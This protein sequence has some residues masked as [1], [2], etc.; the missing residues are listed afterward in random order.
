[1]NSPHR[2]PGTAVLAVAAG[3]LLASCSSAGAS[4]SATPGTTGPTAPGH[5][6][7][8]QV[9]VPL[10]GALQHL[11]L[12]DSTGR[13]RSLGDFR[14]KVLVLAPGMTLC[15]DS[16]PID[17]AGLVATARQV[18]R[19][20][21]RDKVEFVTVTVDPRRD[22]P[23][24]LAAYRKLFKPAPANW[25][26]LTGSQH[27]VMALWHTL[28]VYVKKVKGD[29]QPPPKNWRTGQP[30]RYDVDHSDEVFF[31]D[32][33]QHDRF[34]LEGM[35]HVNHSAKVP[36][37]LLAFMGKQGRANVAHPMGPVWTVPQAVHVVSWL[38]GERIPI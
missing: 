34:V 15:Q 35:P 3:C 37:S 21:L 12:R 1:M 18:D 31:F 28:G 7:G 27:D 36:A 13:Q 24:Q 4:P 19:A 30:L 29:Q 9:D 5:N 2:A 32:A 22:T 23:A 16:C 6:V 11:Q 26:T 25:L 8:T 38:T 17:T 20:G 14:G 33:H 10:T